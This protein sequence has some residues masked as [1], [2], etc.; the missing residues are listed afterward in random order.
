MNATNEKGCIPDDTNIPE[1]KYDKM[2]ELNIH[3]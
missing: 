2:G 3:K 1:L